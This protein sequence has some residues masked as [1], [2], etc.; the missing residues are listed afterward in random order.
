MFSL[1]HN[2]QGLETKAMLNHQS[3]SLL[4]ASVG[5]ANDLHGFNISPHSTDPVNINREGH[6]I[7][8]ILTELIF[9]MSAIGPSGHDFML[10]VTFL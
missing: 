6:L 2:I 8:L 1:K 9:Y 3:V 4:N 10:L 7:V 5:K